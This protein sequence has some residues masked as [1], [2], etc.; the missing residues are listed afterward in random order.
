MYDCIGSVFYVGFLLC[1]LS[2]L[3]VIDFGGF[4]LFFL[5]GTHF[6]IRTVGFGIFNF[7]KVVFVEE[8]VK[9]RLLSFHLCLGP[10]VPGPGV[11]FLCRNSKGLFPG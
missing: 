3:D 10:G 6:R 9:D 7:E 1:F 5:P 11:D 4:E 8:I 2:F